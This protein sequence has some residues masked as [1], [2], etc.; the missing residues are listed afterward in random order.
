MD[1]TEQNFDEL[2]EK[3]IYCDSELQKTSISGIDKDSLEACLRKIVESNPGAN[4]SLVQYSPQNRRISFYT[5]KSISIIEWKGEPKPPIST[6]KTT[7]DVLE[8][9]KSILL[10]K[11]KEEQGCLSI[12][13]SDS[14]ISIYEIKKIVGK[15]ALE[16]E[17]MQEYYVE[18]ITSAYRCRL[19][20][21]GNAFVSK[22]DYRNKKLKMSFNRYRFG[23]YSY[24]N[25]F[26][27]GE[28]L[29][30]EKGD[31]YSGVDLDDILVSSGNI[32]SELYD[33]Y[34]D[35]EDFVSQ[36][37]S[38]IRTI[39][40]KFYVSIDRC[41]INLHTYGND[42]YTYQKLFSL[43]HKSS[44]SNYKYDCN[45]NN[46]IDILKDREDEL[47]KKIY[48]RIED[49]PEW[50]HAQL[51]EK[52]TQELEQQKKVECMQQ[53]QEKKRQKRIDLRKKIT[54]FFK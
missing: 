3:I 26:K 39:N 27:N 32:I 9:I 1:G 8:E 6:L 47:F 7:T 43:S 31:R 30:A 34:L 33:K 53:E 29:Q 36:S 21:N 51:Y 4:F 50:M 41:G 20:D 23:A 49:C 46:I 14:I 18:R 42:L 54:S 24:Y 22:F 25:F 35:Y 5:D 15:K 44:D 48:V 37:S 12:F 28:D 17:Q 2:K 10:E 52:R 19:D 16:Y 38:N 40:S 45:S 11:K 13:D